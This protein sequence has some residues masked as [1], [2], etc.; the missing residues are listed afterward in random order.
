MSKSIN[1]GDLVDALAAKTGSTKA[2]AERFLNALQSV[3]VDFLKRKLDIVLVGFL[4]FKVAHRP[5]STARNPR[6][7]QEIKVAAKNTVKV[8][9]G[10]NLTDAVN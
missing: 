4:S 5:A 10:K 3:V 9:A 6:T 2:D 1:K 7:G 8:K